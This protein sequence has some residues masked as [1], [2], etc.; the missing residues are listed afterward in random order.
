MHRTLTKQKYRQIYLFMN[1]SSF[2]ETAYL[3]FGLLYVFDDDLSLENDLIKPKS[4][5]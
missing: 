2:H 3:V 1:M 5:C 4:F